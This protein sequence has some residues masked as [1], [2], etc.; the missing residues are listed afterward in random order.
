MGKLISLAV[1][2]FRRIVLIFNIILII[3]MA[4]VVLC[5][6]R[7]LFCI[8]LF[9]LIG[10]KAYALYDSAAEVRQKMQHT[11]MTLWKK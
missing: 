7:S 2:L 10:P 1:L 8:Y 9:I 5:S 6:L 4:L 3:Y 11:W